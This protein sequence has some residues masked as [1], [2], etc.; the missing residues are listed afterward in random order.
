LR[1]L[2]APSVVHKIE[3]ISFQGLSFE[4]LIWSRLDFAVV[5]RD[6]CDAMD[7][8][9]ASKLFRLILAVLVTAGLSLS[10]AHAGDSP[11]KARMVMGMEMGA[12]A[13]QHCPSCP[14][15]DG[16]A[17]K[18]VMICG[19]VCPAPILA[20]APQIAEALQVRVRPLFAWPPSPLHGRTPPP[21]PY[22]PKPSRTV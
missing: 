1:G 21:E 12:A 13:H 6:H 10:V 16:D 2:G 8:L 17:H 7:R 20:V 11:T 14:K 15:G 3:S 19:N 9:S 4:F 5:Q 18:A 22:H